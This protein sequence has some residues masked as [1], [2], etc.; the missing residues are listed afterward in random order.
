MHPS[1]NKTIYPQKVIGYTELSPIWLNETYH[2]VAKLQH[3]VKWKAYGVQF[4][5]QIFPNGVLLSFNA[6]QEKFNLPSSMYFYH[7]QLGHA[8]VTQ[9]WSSGGRNPQLPCLF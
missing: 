6:S 7:V 3:G 8:V 1:W 5:S 9:G 4:L 2:E